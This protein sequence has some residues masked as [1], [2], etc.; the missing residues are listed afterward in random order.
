MI[1]KS[2]NRFSDKDHAPGNQ[3]ICVAKIGAAHGVRGEVRLWPFTE[4]PMRL[5]D[6]NPLETADGARR[7]VIATLRPAKD[8][9]VARFEGIATRDAA[10][11]LNGLE[12]FV[13]RDRLPAPEAG[14]YYHADLIGLAAVSPEGDAIGRIVAVHNFGAGDILELM[15]ADGKISVMLSFTDAVIPEVDIA[16]GKIV[17]RM[18]DE[19][20]ADDVSEASPPESNASP[21]HDSDR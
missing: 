6:Y 19:V 16:A 8:H 12:L 11:A 21:R 2:A 17:V 18:P 14:E 9:L 20:P 10:E 3:R 13:P 4:D 5:R 15:P 7:F 1:P